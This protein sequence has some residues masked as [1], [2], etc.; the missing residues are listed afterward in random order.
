MARIA[1]LFLNKALLGMTLA[2]VLLSSDCRAQQNDVR[3]YPMDESSLL[4]QIEGPGVMDKCYLFG[5]M[6]LISAESFFF[7]KKLEKALS[8]SEQL[9]MEIPGTDISQELVEEL[10]LLENG[11][12]KDY[13]DSAQLDSLKYWAKDQLGIT[14]QMFAFA[15]E[16]L[17]PIAVVQIVMQASASNDQMSY[18][19]KLEE[20]ATEIELTINGLETYQEQ[21]SFFDSLD[22]AMQTEMI[23]QS[24]RENSD[25]AFFDQQMLALY[26]SQNI[27][28]LYQLMIEDDSFDSRMQAVFL[29]DRNIKWIPKIKENIRNARTFIAVGAGHLGGPKGLIRLLETEGYTL[30]PIKL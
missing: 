8:K 10:L 2:F 4:W 7:P 20:I 12:L 26:T 3:S 28:G 21:L 22:T 1:S 6:H 9:I 5:T 25:D 27:D 29:D 17:K 16:T 23:M 18:E 15:F 19:I 30:T 14:D 24:I 11:S 13:L